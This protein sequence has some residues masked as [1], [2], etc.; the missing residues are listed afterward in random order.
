M[1]PVT[2][3]SHLPTTCSELL[4]LRGSPVLLQLATALRHR[5][6]TSSAGTAE[7]ESANLQHPPS[8]EHPQRAQTDPLGSGQGPRHHRRWVP[9]WAKAG[10][11]P[12]AGGDPAS[13]AGFARCPVTSVHQAPSSTHSPICRGS[14]CRNLL[15]SEG[16][17]LRGNQTNPS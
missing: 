4:G 5:G 1:I 9:A 7:E 3:R 12:R 14:G 8:R 16:H 10:P 2:T 15:R 17:G 6:H 11:P 13:Q